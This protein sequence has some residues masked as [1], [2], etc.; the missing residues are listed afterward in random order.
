MSYPNQCIAGSKL[1]EALPASPYTQA[2]CDNIMLL[3][4]PEETWLS[5]MSYAVARAQCADRTSIASTPLAFALLRRLYG[6]LS[7]RL[8]SNRYQPSLKLIGGSCA[9]NGKQIGERQA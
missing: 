6:R 1:R 3:A 5:G 2:V 9:I 8:A 4:E 7:A